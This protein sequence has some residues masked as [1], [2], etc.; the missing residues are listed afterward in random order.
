[1]RTPLARSGAL[2]LA[3]GV[4]HLC[5]GEEEVLFFSLSLS[6][7]FRQGYGVE[8]RGLTPLSL[9]LFLAW[10]KSPGLKAHP[11]RRLGF[12]GVRIEHSASN[13]LKP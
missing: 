3:V 13:G 8:C 5:P 1:M 9:S 7:F 11:I 2:V 4:T 6:Y 10:S 12:R